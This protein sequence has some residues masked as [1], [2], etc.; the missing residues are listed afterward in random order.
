MPAIQ[1]ILD[2]VGFAAI[3][4]IIGII[5]NSKNS[6]GLLNGLTNLFVGTFNAAASTIR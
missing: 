2:I 5:A 4:L 6:I 1:G 3:A